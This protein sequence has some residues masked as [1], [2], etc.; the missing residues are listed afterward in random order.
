MIISIITAILLVIV[1]ILVLAHRFK[2]DKKTKYIVLTITISALILTIIG[3][4][5][6]NSQRQIT[7]EL[8]RTI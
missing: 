4:I 6:E 2:E 8:S 1:N 5:N 7:K 3:I